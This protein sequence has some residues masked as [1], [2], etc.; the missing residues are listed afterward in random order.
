MVRVRLL[1]LPESAHAQL[2]V[3]PDWDIAGPV[4][5]RQAAQ[6]GSKIFVAGGGASALARAAKE[7]KMRFMMQR[8]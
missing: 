3:L 2:P 4:A 7:V 5:H 8:C 6:R 1:P